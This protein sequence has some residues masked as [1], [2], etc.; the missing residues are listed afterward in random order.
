MSIN[1]ERR[2]ET[3]L[4]RVLAA[5]LEKRQV[6]LFLVL[7]LI[8][9]GI[10]A[11]TRLPIDA[12]PDVSNIQVEIIAQ[13]PGLSPFEIER[14][15]TF[16]I[17][18]AM[19]GL[20][21]LELMRSVTKFGLSVVTLIFS[22]RTD[23]YFA[24]QLVFERLGEVR[25]KLPEEVEISLGPVST[26]LGEIYQY[27]LEVPDLEIKTKE[28]EIRWLTELRTI[29]DWIVAP[30]LKTVPGVNEINSFGG[31]I[32]QIHVRPEPLWLRK[33]GLTVTDVLTAI[34]AGN[35]NVGGSIIDHQ[36]EQIIVRGVGLYRTLEDVEQVVIKA[37]GGVPIRVRDVAEVAS[38][39]AVR[40]G[41][42][43]MNGE[44][45]V[46][47]GIVMMLRGEN[48]RQVVKR[49]EAKVEEIN[50]ENVLP[51]G[52]KI[53]PFYRRSEIVEKSLGT[54]KYAILE[55]SI[56]VLIVLF[57]F[58]GNLRG[59]IIVIMAMPLT[60]LATFVLARLFNLG[61]NLMSLGGLAIS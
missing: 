23:I 18:V 55:G 9:A 21:Q 58:L 5:C 22:D 4:E 16:P 26:A 41:A 35:R 14:L 32:K 24:R 3:F 43:L 17:E 33:Y 7:V 51:H 60:V 15:V 27:I 50:R 36:G 61:A 30:L 12:F 46:V 31:Y 48:S 45:E 52:I 42:S 49:V 53:K 1:I 20:P 40:Q 25:E 34:E 47:G 39:Y 56:L 2:Q 11:L 19:R 8:G 54:V 59:A 13:A 28:E 37:E 57:L 6:I 29:Q 44:K 38:G 10:I